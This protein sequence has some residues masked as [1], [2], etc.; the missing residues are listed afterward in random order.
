[1]ARMLLAAAPEAATVA[2]DRG[3][4]PI[5]LAALSSADGDTISLL[6]AAAPQTAAVRGA[7]GLTPLHCAAWAGAVAALT[8]LLAAAPAAA[9]VRDESGC[10][11]LK[12]AV[13]RLR[14]EIQYGEGSDSVRHLREAALCLIEA[15]PPADC[16]AIATHPPLRDV[17]LPLFPHI[18]ACHALTEA[19]WQLVPSP[20]P[21]LAA[22]LPAVYRRSAAEAALLV[23]HLPPADR[24]R[25]RTAALCLTCTQN[26]LH[27]HLPG[28]LVGRILSLFDAT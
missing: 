18:V 17:C 9:L 22:A 20:C 21:G 16:L 5:H 12:K 1:M 8:A 4:L 26:Q 2:T 19:E 25:L 6:L 15:T 11:P 10:L 27:V 28:P 3:D 24:L 14:N 13:L 23:A 7:G